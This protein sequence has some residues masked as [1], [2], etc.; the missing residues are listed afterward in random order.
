MKLSTVSHVIDFYVSRLVL[1]H[2]DLV[3]T[4]L[5][6]IL[7]F[8]D[9]QLLNAACA[10]RICSDECL[11]ALQIPSLCKKDRLMA[12]RLL[13]ALFSTPSTRQGLIS[14]KFEL[15][16]RFIASVE[17]EKDPECLM[18]I[19]PMHSIVLQHFELGHMAE[20]H[21]DCMAAYF[22]VDYA[23]PPGSPLTVAR[24]ELVDKLHACLFAS[25]HLDGSLLLPLL[26]EKANS[27]W[28]EGRTDALALLADCLVGLP[29]AASFF[30]DFALNLPSGV[31][32]DPIPANY[33]SAYLFAICNMV[34]ELAIE[35]EASDR[36]D[37]VRQ[38]LTIVAG[39]AIMHKDESAD[40]DFV[41]AFLDSLWSEKSEKEV[42]RLSGWFTL[43]PAGTESPLKSPPL[44]LASDCI[45]V[46]AVASLNGALL[47]R[48]FQRLAEP[49]LFPKVNPLPSD[50]CYYRSKFEQLTVWTPHLSFLNRVLFHVSRHRSLSLKALQVDETQA[51]SIIFN[52]SHTLKRSCSDLRLCAGDRQRCLAEIVAFNLLCRV[53]SYCTEV[54]EDVRKAFLEFIP[55]VLE[56]TAPS[57]DTEANMNVLR[58]EQ[59]VLLSRIVSEPSPVG[60]GLMRLLLPIIEKNLSDSLECAA[61]EI[62]QRAS[63]NNSDIFKSLFTLLFERCSDTISMPPASRLVSSLL[64]VAKSLRRNDEN[65]LLP[66]LASF[67]QNRV[68]NIIDLT[69][70]LITALANEKADICL[71]DLL[72]VVRL[73]TSG[74]SEEQQRIAFASFLDSTKVAKVS[75]PYS[76]ILLDCAVISA[77]YPTLPNTELQ[78]IA[79]LLFKYFTLY[80]SDFSINLALQGIVAHEMCFCAATLLNKFSD[81][82]I[83][84]VITRI[85]DLLLTHK[86]ESF[87]IPLT[88]RFV[89][90]SL[91][92]L[93]TSQLTSSPDRQNI[94]DRFTSLLLDSGELGLQDLQRAC[95][96]D[97]LHLLLQT[98]T[99]GEEDVL[100]L[101]AD[102][103]HCQVNPLA[104]QKCYCLVGLRLRAAWEKSKMHISPSSDNSLEAAFLHGYLRLTSL[105]PDEIIGDYASDALEAS[106]LAV[107]S[108]R[109]PLSTQALALSIVSR[110]V[111]AAEAV[112]SNFASSAISPNC[113]D[114][115]F[116]KLLHLGSACADTGSSPTTVSNLHFNLARCLRFLVG[117]SPS[118]TS[119]HRV[120][121]RRLLE[122]LLDD[123]CQSVRLEASRAYNE[124]CLKV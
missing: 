91:R 112:D 72:S 30:S 36:T 2:P 93:L 48:L 46:A 97:N 11:D 50:D 29:Q 102:I 26:L 41:E 109:Y 71:T 22:P 96:V 58:S 74:L 95:L 114:D 98:S 81:K 4:L 18:L 85:L 84:E 123:D 121:V 15:I 47:V 92:S 59:R 40:V 28:Q 73:T 66:F 16:R 39:L 99:D 19:F 86:H 14:M 38:L 45:V 33:V 101:N 24:S 53:L 9:H 64:F 87:S 119:R 108:G 68:N 21:F 43:P 55:H 25:R 67:L 27:S 52:L 51:L 6:G 117:L 57:K 104:V 94:V 105:L 54:S 61:I 1:F 63:C 111:A 17:R 20:E 65:R 79:D 13:H 107:T 75:S 60:D 122:G 78:A 37:N 90:L 113:A 49:L 7:W 100:S 35:L 56:H 110:L 10:I 12:F 5:E 42:M 118:V 44:G 3:T 88:S 70:Y 34:R 69:D 83:T 89:L 23:P 76:T 31:E 106:V 116:A 32:E 77:V 103:L 62:L 120:G 82:A 80:T 8:A 124:W 115:F